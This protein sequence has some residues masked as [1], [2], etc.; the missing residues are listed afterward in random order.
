MNDNS[1][2][3][4]DLTARLL[5]RLNSLDPQVR[6]H[7]AGRLL[8]EL[9]PQ[10]AVDVLVELLARKKKGDAKVDESLTSITKALSALGDRDEASAIYAEAL[11][12][13]ADD[14]VGLVMRPVPARVFDP[15]K[16]L[17]VDHDMRARTVGMRRQMARRADPVEL[18]RLQ[19]D[20][21]PGVIENLLM[22][23]RLTEPEVVRMAARRP[24]RPQVLATIFKSPR[25][26]AS[27]RVRKALAHN[28]YTS[29]EMALKL[30]PLLPLQDV[31]ELAASRE[32]HDEVRRSARA[33]IA[34]AEH[35][36]RVSR[37]AA[38]LADME[39]EGDA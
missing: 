21:D 13:R 17:G 4:R 37:A 8:E 30:I 14:V 33:R 2:M 18:M 38:N 5:R 7:A 23:P 15:R 28:P 1:S 36:R 6:L 35:R 16:E 25:W 32:I 34:E 29:P 24:G 22:H 27:R 3:S 12:R 39:P 11:A 19:T 20:P 31:R 10:Q 9:S 26:S